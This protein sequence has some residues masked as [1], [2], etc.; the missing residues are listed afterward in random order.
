[1]Y[2]YLK[3]GK[4]DKNRLLKE[5]KFQYIRILLLQSNLKWSTI[6]DILGL[7]LCIDVWKF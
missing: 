2:M 5:L 1:M 4:K 7:P 3:S 6:V